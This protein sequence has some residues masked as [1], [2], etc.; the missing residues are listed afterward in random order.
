MDGSRITDVLIGGAIGV[1][2]GMNGIAL[3]GL[4]LVGLGFDVAVSLVYR[5]NP[6]WF[7]QSGAL[8]LSDVLSTGLGTTLGWSLVQML[9]ERIRTNPAARAVTAAGFV[10]L[11]TAGRVPGRLRAAYRLR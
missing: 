9:P 4:L 3:P 7:P 2:G 10:F 1:A 8:S 11:P 5:I 6:N